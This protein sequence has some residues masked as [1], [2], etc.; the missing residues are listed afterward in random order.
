MFPLDRQKTLEAMA[1]LL[2]QSSSKRMKY[3][4]LLKLLYI[5]DRETLQ[6]KGHP[7]TG[8]PTSAMPHGPVNSYVCDFVRRRFDVPVW[9][10]YIVPEGYWLVLIE[11][12][13]V[14]N[15]SKYEIRKLTEVFARYKLLNQF[16]LRDITHKFPEWI[17]N[18][19]GNSSR[20]IPL[21]DILEGVGKAESVLG[22]EEEAEAA[23]AIERVFGL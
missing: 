14:E 15:L 13:G 4:K 16:Q 19:P 12:P 22:V 11:S 6:D 21:R 5:A 17:K 7:I 2:G 9:T 10:R 1:L 20:P 18:N 23:S 8:G 3:L